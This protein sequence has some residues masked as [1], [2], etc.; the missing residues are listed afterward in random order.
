M[1]CCRKSIAQVFAEAKASGRAAFIPFTT[2]GYKTT[3]DTVDVMLALQRGGANII[4]VRALSLCR[5][6]TGVI[7][8]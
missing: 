3:A 7:L 2:C 5:C 4:E 8:G 1:S 6:S